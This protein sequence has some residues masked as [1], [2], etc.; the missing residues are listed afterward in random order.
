MAN[1]Q[2]TMTEFTLAPGE[3][4]LVGEHFSPNILLFWLKTAVAASNVRVQYRSPNTIL[5]IIPLGSESQTIPLKNIASVDTSTKFNMGNFV[6]G[7]IFLI[8]G[9]ASFRGS[10]FLGIIMLL[11][12][13]VNFC[14]MITASLNFMNQAGGKNTVTVSIL[15]KDKLSRLAQSIQERVF[16]DM[17]G[18]R[19][20]ESM[21]LGQQQ[22]S[23]QA[24][25]AL[26]QQQMLEAQKAAA[27]Q[28]NDSHAPT[29]P[30]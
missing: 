18:L 1:N 17:D 25:Q 8:V 26:L 5:G 23:V 3:K 9:F 15:E 14:N 29:S 10:P 7:V 2:S 12:A 21:N 27:H 6:L 24:Q 30:Q 20:Q 16:A 4:D 22:F 19:H 13:A 28:G 11:L